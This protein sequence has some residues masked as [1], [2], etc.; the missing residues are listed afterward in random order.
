MTKKKTSMYS[1]LF[2]FGLFSLMSSTAT[3]QAVFQTPNDVSVDCQATYKRAILLAQEYEAKLPPVERKM[4]ETIADRAVKNGASRADGYNEYGGG[5]MM[6]G[7]FAAAAW[8]ALKAVTLELNPN[9]VSNVGVYLTYLNRYDDADIFLSCADKMAPQ[10]S[11][12]IEGRAM[13]AYRQR[14]YRNATQLIQQAVRMMPGD[15]NVRYTAGVIFYKAGDSARAKQFLNEALQMAPEYQTTINALKVVD[16]AGSAVRRP[17]P[18]PTAVRN[19]VDECLRFMDAMIERAESDARRKDQLFQLEKY[20]SARETLRNRLSSMLLVVN[21]QKQIILA[22]EQATGQSL[23]FA[24]RLGPSA[25]NA[26][27]NQCIV[28]YFITLEQYHQVADIG[29]EEELMAAVQGVEPLTL[30][31]KIMAGLG[32]WG[33]GGPAAYILQD[34]GKKNNDA[35][36]RA[37][38]IFKRS[39]EACPVDR[40]VRPCREAAKLAYCAEA[41]P[42]WKEHQTQLVRTAR[43]AKDGLEPALT[44]YADEWKLWANQASGYARRT[45]GVMKEPTPEARRLTGGGENIGQWLVRAKEAYQQYVAEDTIKN[46]VVPRLEASRKTLEESILYSRTEVSPG[47]AGSS[48]P[49]HAPLECFPQTTEAITIDELLEKIGAALVEASKFDSSFEPD[50]ELEIGGWKKS[51]KPL[52]LGR[53][54]NLAK[55]K[56]PGDTAVKVTVD[57]KNDRWGGQYGKSFD[58]QYGPLTGKIGVKVWGEGNLTGG[59]ADFGIQADG[60]VGIGLKKSGVGGAACYFGTVSYKFSARTFAEALA[61]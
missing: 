3:A 47:G 42:R 20:D 44:R 29:A 35:H 51:F 43:L 5:A 32:D 53:D 57:L 56:L 39:E 22:L 25:W 48:G 19:Q 11:F 30:I 17:S 10:S 15:L 50:C 6:Q 36:Q 58:A 28:S 24:P 49:S 45:L 13:L 55:G 41:L 27:L 59:D 52:S 2:W 61:R 12:V 46:G 38:E 21:G 16:P 8:G 7:Q 37:Y 23:S 40:D 33:T 34:E 26:I 60:K 1:C 14:D 4:A 18:M 31:G 9:H 54:I